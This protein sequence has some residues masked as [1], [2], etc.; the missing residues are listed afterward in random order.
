MLRIDGNELE[1]VTEN[2]AF[3]FKFLDGEQLSE[4]LLI[5]GLQSTKRVE[6]VD[7]ARFNPA[8]LGM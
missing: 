3:D 7:D 4:A 8:R 5:L 6:F 2:G 1:V